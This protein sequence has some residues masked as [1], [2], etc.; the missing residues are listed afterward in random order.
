MPVPACKVSPTLAQ[1]VAQAT[2]PSQSRLPALT[3]SLESCPSSLAALKIICVPCGEQRDGS[4]PGEL[5]GWGCHGQSG[6]VVGARSL[7]QLQGLLCPASLQGAGGEL[8]GKP[9]GQRW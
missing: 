7:L 9:R 4:G 3:F 2:C 8:L 6:H 5:L 1:R